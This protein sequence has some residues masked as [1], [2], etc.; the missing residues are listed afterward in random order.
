MN[1]TPGKLLSL[2]QAVKAREKLRRAGRK[3]VLTNGVF[4]LLHP[5]HR[6]FLRHA[7]RPGRSVFVALNSNRSVR[8]LKGKGRPV[9]G[10]RRRA[11]NLARLPE[12]KGIVIFRKQRLTRQILALKPDIYVKAGDYTLDKLDPGERAALEKVGA[13][14]EFLPFLPGHSTTRLIRKM[15]A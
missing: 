10:E 11:R 13:K 1:P 8:E 14:I 2:D 4:D 6:H 3:F 7:H 15:K 5:G 12:V 9:E